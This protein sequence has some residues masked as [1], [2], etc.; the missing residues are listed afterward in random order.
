M[1]SEKKEQKAFYFNRNKSHQGPV[2]DKNRVRQ[3]PLFS[4][5]FEEPLPHAGSILSRTVL[6][7][8]AFD[9]KL[10]RGSVAT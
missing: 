5:S 10:S 4:L 2:Q 6:I 1:V 9:K 8:L 3:Y 7:P